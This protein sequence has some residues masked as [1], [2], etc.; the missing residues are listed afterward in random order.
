M[1]ARKK[2]NTT[3]RLERCAEYIT[4][5]ITVGTKPLHLEIGCGKGKFA[6]ETAAQYDCDYFALEKVPDVMVIAAEKAVEAEQIVNLLQAT[7]T[8]LSIQPPSKKIISLVDFLN[9]ES[10]K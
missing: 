1:R 3:P 7:S 8:P 2:K 4:E 10:K 6:V 9:K 5:E